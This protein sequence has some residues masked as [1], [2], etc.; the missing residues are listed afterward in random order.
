MPDT[1]SAHSPR[2]RPARRRAS[3]RPGPRLLAAVVAVV[4]VV[5]AVLLLSCGGTESA[6][7]T[8]ARAFSKGP[9]VKTANIELKL[10]LSAGISGA[11]QPLDLTVGG[12]YVANQKGHTSFNLKVRLSGAQQ[13]DA[14]ALA[15][16]GVG[17]K[18]YVTIGGQAFTVS[19]DVAKDLAGKD[20]K[21]DDG[22]SFRTLGI[23][24]GAW[25]KDPK[26]IGEEQFGGED[27]THVQANVDTAR[28]AADLQKLLG[29]AQKAA[30]AA[31]QTKAA[32]AAI[33]KLQQDIK[34]ARVDLWVAEGDGALRRMKLDVTVASGTVS[35]DLTLS[36]INQPVTIPAAKNPM[37]LKDLLTALEKAG[38]GSGDASGA[39]SA[40]GGAATGGTAT[41][42]DGSDSGDATA[43]AAPGA[44][45]GGD[46]SAYDACVSDADGDIT[47]LQACK[48]L[49]P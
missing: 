17:G 1:P 11:D 21:G 9:A 30:D 27:V 7:D 13:T 47:K 39:S 41:T 4:V 6:S 25:L 20:A 10:Q 22:L 37:P 2:R 5:V 8:V 28:F 36:K 33:K 48:D 43:P 29:R 46:Q 35:L 15:L 40:D 12:P 24:P 3:Q 38:V 45:A 49:A 31:K 14:D 32:A 18:T 34:S 26:R 42:P 16:L 23:D 44:G 19:N